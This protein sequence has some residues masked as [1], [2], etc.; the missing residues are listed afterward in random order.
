MTFCFFGIPKDPEEYGLRFQLPSRRLC[1]AK[2]CNGAA[3]VTIAG[4][5]IR[6]KPVAHP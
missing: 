4:P 5:T 6:R 2:Y 3:F 1:V